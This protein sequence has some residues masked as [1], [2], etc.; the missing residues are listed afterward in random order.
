MPSTHRIGIVGYS[1]TKF[2]K[3]QA[4]AILK[5]A[6]ALRAVQHPDCSVVSGLTD[7]GIPALAYREA[8]E[9]GMRTVGIACKKAQDY[10]CYPCDDVVIEGNDWGDESET[11]LSSI[12]ELIKVGGGKQS[13][14]EF[15]AFQGSKEEFPLEPLE[16]I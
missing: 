15:A 9:L 1:G 13:I 12:D 8:A 16:P 14:A 6:L 3:G 7:L 10:D 11:F 4:K 2:D 5:E